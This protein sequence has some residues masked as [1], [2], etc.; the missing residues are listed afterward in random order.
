M[1]RCR[2][3]AVQEVRQLRKDRLRADSDDEDRARAGHDPSPR[4][5]GRLEPRRQRSS[6]D[7]QQDRQLPF[8]ISQ[9]NRKNLLVELDPRRAAAGPPGRGD[10]ARHP[11]AP[12]AK[13]SLALAEEDLK[14][15]RPRADAS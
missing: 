7:Q 9:G 11:Q 1:L 3:R 14:T 5:A 12:N 13:E 4:P 10:H 2:R 6:A 15:D 8:D